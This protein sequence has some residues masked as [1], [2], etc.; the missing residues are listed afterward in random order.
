MSERYVIVA[1][2]QRGALQQAEPLSDFEN[3]NVID[4][5]E[6]AERACCEH[7]V[8]IP[9]GF[10]NTGAIWRP[11]YERAI[12]ARTWRPIERRNARPAA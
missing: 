7:G 3:A 5:L 10:D 12:Y 11:E 8:R 2:M 9:T 4:A 6:R 1:T